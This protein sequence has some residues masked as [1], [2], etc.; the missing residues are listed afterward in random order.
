MC[1][2]AS[3]FLL[4]F[5]FVSVFDENPIS[6]IY[7]VEKGRSICIYFLVNNEYSFVILLLYQKSVND[8]SSN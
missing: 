6:Q 4:D 5:V 7:S 1:T 2:L 8:I 3:N